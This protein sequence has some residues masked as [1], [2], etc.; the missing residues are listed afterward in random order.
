MTSKVKKTE[1]LLVGNQSNDS[2]SLVVMSN[3]LA[4]ARYRLDLIEQKLFLYM[5]S[6]I[7]S[8]VVD[9][10]TVEFTLLDFAKESGSDI[11]ELYKKINKIV[12]KLLGLVIEI[13]ENETNWDMYNISSK[14]SYRSG[15]ITYKFNADMK[16]FLLEL[17][18]SN[19]LYH[20]LDVPIKFQSKYSIKVYLYLKANAYRKTHKNG[21]YIDYMDFRRM[22]G[23]DDKEY[24][25]FKNFRV[26]VIEVALAEINSSSDLIV[27]YEK[28]TEGHNKV[29]GLKFDVDVL[30]E[31]AEHKN[32]KD[33]SIYTK[34]FIDEIKKL[35]GLEFA[36]FAAKTV[37]ELHQIAAVKF[38]E[39]PYKY[40]WLNYKYA[41]NQSSV[42]HMGGY[43][44][45]C[46]KDDLGRAKIQIE[47]GIETEY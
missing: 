9:F 34:D 10:G 40:I 2:R 20:Y 17:K 4:E 28:I 7:D 26:K 42:T 30:S 27:S 35:S 41:L 29:I 16:I 36:K 47:T 5:V 38:K 39:D 1:T 6:K 21:I 12:K 18:N 3:K 44:K 32:N 24:A 13:K 19:V 45:K 43:L 37:V 8:E 14:C 15:K 25:I 22:L 23:V 11:K 33:K 46:L 31:K